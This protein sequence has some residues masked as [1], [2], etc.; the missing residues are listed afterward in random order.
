MV[1]GSITRVL[2]SALRPARELARRALRLPPPYV[3]TPACSVERQTIRFRCQGQELELEADASTPLYETVFQIVDRDCYQLAKLPPPRREALVIDIGANVGV[4]SVLAAKLYS[5]RV[6]AYEPLPNNCR[7]LRRNLERNAVQNVFV[8][9]EAVV[10]QDGPVQF[11]VTPDSVGGHVAIEGR[12]ENSSGPIEVPGIG[13]QSVLSGYDNI[14]LIKLDCEGSEYEI[15]S[16]ITAC[17]SKRVRALTFE[18]HDLDR[19]RNVKRLRHDLEVRLG[20]K[21]FYRPDIYGQA[22]GH[23]VLAI[24]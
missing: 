11:V 14:D 6:V 5:G 24:R 10:G 22:E 17:L 4:F 9:E 1:D 21:T 19:R 15:V 3:W 23:Y 16:H 18:V 12:E 2:K 20:Y 13:I 8:A 7:L